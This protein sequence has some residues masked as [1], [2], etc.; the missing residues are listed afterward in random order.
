MHIKSISAFTVYPNFRSNFVHN[1]FIGANL[2]QDDVFVQ[3]ADSKSEVV[4]FDKSKEINECY[5]KIIRSM[6]LISPE[7]IENIAKSVRK[8]L[9]NKVSMNDIYEVMEILTQFSDYKSI[10]SLKEALLRHDINRISNL[11]EMYQSKNYFEGIPITLTNIFH[12]LFLKNFGFKTDSPE[13]INSSK[14][15]GLI[16]DTELLD[17]LAEY[18]DYLS[19]DFFNKNIQGE[20]VR[21]IYI[22]NF[23]NGYN[24][25]SRD[26]S[27]EDKTYEIIKNA[28]KLDNRKA[29]KDNVEHI[30]N[31]P[32]IRKMHELGIKPLVIENN[33]IGGIDKLQYPERIA[34]NLNPLTI[35]RKDFQDFIDNI[36]KNSKAEQGILPKYYLDFL[37]KMTN[38]VTPTQYTNYLKILYSKLADYLKMQGKSMDNVYFLI[39]S[40]SKSFVVANYQ[41]QKVN[42]IPMKNNIYFKYIPDLVKYDG[43]I[44]RLPNNSTLVL[45]DD[46][47]I[48]G[49]SMVNE[50][51]NYDYIAK[52]FMLKNKNVGMVFAPMVATQNAIKRIRSAINR[53]GKSTVDSIITSKILPEWNDSSQSIKHLYMHVVPV[54]TGALTS[55]VFPYMGPD[56]NCSKFVPFYQKFLPSPNAQEITIDEF[57]FE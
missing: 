27:L 25:L 2:A 6:N 24:F 29:L 1:S 7:N 34:K 46:C 11:T 35:S 41:F 36:S 5:D 15:K 55:L 13:E 4:L 40:T 12:Y 8:K 19:K 31:E 3:G 37:N 32:L 26:T 9:K 39:P 28:L 57:C 44:N 30:L 48:S 14:V 21:P 50:V 33:M 56:N 47:A 17:L 52:A 18:K 49:A 43:A 54:D 45:L 42:N 20:N 16:I 22:K 38:I 51:F 10:I 23:E 53:N